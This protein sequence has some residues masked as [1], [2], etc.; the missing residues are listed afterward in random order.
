VY[1][2]RSNV[3]YTPTQTRH[4][5]ARP[6]ATCVLR[7]RGFLFFG[8]A[9]A[10]QKAACECISK[11]E[12]HKEKLQHL[13]I[14][15][16]HCAGMD[17]SVATAL[18]TIDALTQKRDIVLLLAEARGEAKVIIDPMVEASSAAMVFD[19]LDLALE[20]CER[21][22]L[23]Q[24]PGCSANSEDTEDIFS[25]TH[26]A[27]MTTAKRMRKSSSLSDGVSKAYFNSDFLLERQ[28]ARAA[29]ETLKLNQ[30][31]EQF[32]LE[33]YGRAGISILEVI[34]RHMQPLEVPAD[35]ILEGSEQHKLYFLES[36]FLS[37]YRSP[38]FG[39]EAP[40]RDGIRLKKFGP[41]TFVGCPAALFHASGIAG[42]SHIA[43][44]TAITDTP[45]CVYVMDCSHLE[46]LERDNPAVALE[47]FKILGSIL[48]SRLQDI[49]QSLVT[50]LQYGRRHRA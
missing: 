29:P 10:I 4:L 15:F 22:L 9:R 46:V 23:A 49:E 26:S 39:S 41:G 35:Y 7:M 50:E 18:Q 5:E 36:G 28:R 42:S 8:S 6:G 31:L 43:K 32:L 3:H 37:C 20:E 33:A 21:Q 2:A 48:G 13:V 12:S 19:T 47:F 45:C 40:L 24:V 27:N 30:Q 16:S 1:N 14:D 11:E 34:T 17:S 25:P 38:D 44:T